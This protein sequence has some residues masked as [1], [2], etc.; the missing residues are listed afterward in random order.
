M[1]I[2]FD[3]ESKKGKSP[4]TRLYTSKQDAEAEDNSRTARVRTGRRAEDEPHVKVEKPEIT[5]LGRIGLIISGFIFSGMVLFT[6]AG[7]ERISRAYADINALN[8]EID[9]TELRINELDVQIEC[10]VTIQDAQKVAEAYG[11]RYPEKSQYVKS[12]MR[13]RFP[14]VR[15]RRRP[16]RTLLK[17]HSRTRAER[18]SRIRRP[19]RIRRRRGRYNGRRG[20]ST[21]QRRLIR[22]ERT[23]SYGENDVTYPQD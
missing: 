5:P 16:S 1:D 23:L 3:E 22:N 8:T 15:R 2:R 18:R 4:T 7:Y 20:G 14:A 13:C 21:V 9:S 11:M 19:N 6:L 10:A 17:R 12:A